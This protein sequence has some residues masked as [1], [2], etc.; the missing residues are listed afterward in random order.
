[1]L[2]SAIILF[3]GLR[4]VHRQRAGAYLLTGV[5][6]CMV[7]GLGLG[8][9]GSVI[10]LLGRNETLTGR[11]DIWQMLWNWNVNPII[12]TGFESFWLGDRREAVQNLY[13]GL[14]EAHNGYLETYL[15]LG[16]VGV[17]VILAMLLATFA[18]SNRE[19]LRDF[20]FGRLRMAYL[21]AFIAYN[22][23]E[24]AFRLNAF[25]FFMFFLVAIDIPRLRKYAMEPVQEPYRPEFSLAIDQKM[26][27]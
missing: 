6:V 13:A 27:N 9:F 18:K 21:I 20:E 11:T 23:T 14:N 3:L 12:G 16:A 25:P 10:H 1:M 24:A 2:G 4:W 8:L 15:N 17:I 22:W 26:L 19:L 7:A 5:A